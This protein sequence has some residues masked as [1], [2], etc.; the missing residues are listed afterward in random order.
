MANELISVIIPIYNVEK[1]LHRCVCSVIDQTYTNL[2]IIL[3]D[4]GST[5]KCPEMCDDFVAH[6]ERIK[7][8]H[9]RNDGLSSA[10]NVG[11]QLAV[12]EYI[13]LIDGDDWIVPYM[14]EKMYNRIN[15]DGSDIVICPYQYVDEAGNYIR[16]DLMSYCRLKNG[17]LSRDQLLN[18]IN[19]NESGYWFY[20]SPCTKLYKSFYL[21]KMKYPEHRLFEDEY[22]AHHLFGSINEASIMEE[23]LYMRTVRADSITQLNGYNSLKKMDVIFALEDRYR[24]FKEYHYDVYA[25][26]TAGVL[27]TVFIKIV[28][29]AFK[30]GGDYI[31]YLGY[32]MKISII[33]IRECKKIGLKLPIVY[34]KSFCDNVLFRK[35]SV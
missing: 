6:D 35:S 15:Q 24:F 9:K 7:V 23:C 29:N 11:I 2:E 22:I 13:M 16:E 30:N 3:V 28:K 4:D 8:I 33:Q 14:A 12:G 34:F 5:D 26:D 17:I 21:K 1:Y 20:S 25:R 32:M 18:K 31:R 10:R 27:Y 19:F